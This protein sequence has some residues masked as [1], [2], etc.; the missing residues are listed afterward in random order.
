MSVTRENRKSIGVV[1]HFM[2]LLR[3]LKGT[4]GGLAAIN[5]ALLTEL[6]LLSAHEIEAV[7]TAWAKGGKP[8]K[9][10]AVVRRRRS[11]G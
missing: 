5:M 3:S 4:W 11:P 8:L 7:S 10:F 2:P 9:R 6:F 1:C